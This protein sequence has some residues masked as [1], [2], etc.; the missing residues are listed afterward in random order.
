MNVCG[1]Q[2]P[3]FQASVMKL[4]TVLIWFLLLIFNSAEQCSN[5]SSV[6]QADRHTCYDYR[7]C[8]GKKLYQNKRVNCSSTKD[9]GHGEPGYEGEYCARNDSGEP[10]CT[11]DFNE[12]DGIKCHKEI[13]H[14]E[15]TCNVTND[16]K[17]SVC[18]CEKM[19]FWRLYPFLYIIVG[20]ILVGTFIVINRVKAHKK[21]AL[22]SKIDSEILMRKQDDETEGNV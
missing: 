5:D 4:D 14:S 10:F 6:P 8:F 20:V 11:N 7:L 13:Y 17:Y 18:V 21:A 16:E 2:N 9:H 15:C 19:T 3:F 12:A 22:N 1:Y